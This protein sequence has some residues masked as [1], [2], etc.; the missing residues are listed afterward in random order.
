MIENQE[1]LLFVDEAVYSSTQIAQKVWAPRGLE[2]PM[3]ARN[4]ISF[5]AVAVVAAMDIRG[6]VVAVHMKEKS[7]KK[8]DFLD[9]LSLLRESVKDRQIL[10]LDNLSFHRSKEVKEYCA[11]NEFTIEYNSIYSSQ[12]NAIERLWSFSKR[13]FRREC[14]RTKNFKNKALIRRLVEES[15]YGVPVSP[16]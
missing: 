10:L 16:L 13:E 15:I 8:A 4:K 5:K 11:D 3:V 2:S 12:V 9:F 7:I 6:K 1:N 14:I